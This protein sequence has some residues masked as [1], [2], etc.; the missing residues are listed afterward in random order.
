MYHAESKESN[1]VVMRTYRRC[2]EQC[3]VNLADVALYK[4]HSVHASYA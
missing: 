2:A 1:H 3:V 4:K